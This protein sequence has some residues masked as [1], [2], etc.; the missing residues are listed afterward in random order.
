MFPVIL[1]EEGVELPKEGTYYVVASNGIFIRRDVGL[2]SCLVPVESISFL[3]ELDAENQFTSSLP[4]VPLSIVWQ[5]KKFFNAIVEKY[6]SEANTILYYNRQLDDFRVFVPDQ[7]VS[8]S[9]VN[10]R[11]QPITRMEGMEGYLPV[12]TIHSHCDFSAFHSGT[13][14]ADELNFDGLHCTFG[15]NNKEEISIS[16]SYVF[17]GKRFK[18]EPETVL[19]GVTCTSSSPGQRDKFYALEEEP[20]HSEM[21]RL[22]IQVGKWME[23][24]DGSPASEVRLGQRYELGGP[25]VEY[26]L[27][28]MQGEGNSKN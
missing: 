24:V 5:I 7:R 3:D 19:Q 17:S 22:M 14:D 12:G 6:H 1:M 8:H 18:V 4:K 27:R 16:A 20:H 23:Q 9:G 25:M 28:N 10:Y 15:H 26:F 21:P 11:R 13:D 2:F